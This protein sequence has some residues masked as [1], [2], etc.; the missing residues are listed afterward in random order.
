MDYDETPLADKETMEWVESHING[1]P[2]HDTEPHTYKEYGMAIHPATGVRLAT[3]E[4]RS[5][6]LLCIGDVLSTGSTVVGVIRKKVSEV[7]QTDGIRLTPSTL[8]WNTSENKWKRFSPVSAPVS[9]PVS[10]SSQA[11][12]PV[13]EETF[14]SFVVVPNSQIELSTGLRIRD[15]MEYCSPDTEQ[16]YTQHLEGL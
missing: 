3:G 1:G 15:Y 8:Y 13:T 5:A 7:I 10:V 2:S 6:D 4:I 11:A 14:C 12:T 9:A 16:V